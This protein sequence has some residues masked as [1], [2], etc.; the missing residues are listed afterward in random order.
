MTRSC[1]CLT[2]LARARLLAAGRDGTTEALEEAVERSTGARRRLRLQLRAS[3]AV[4]AVAVVGLALGLV[5][6]LVFF[7][8]IVPLLS[9]AAVEL[10]WRSPKNRETR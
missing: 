7:G 10:W 1:A 4:L 2:Q 3:C 6:P 8:L 9:L 5:R